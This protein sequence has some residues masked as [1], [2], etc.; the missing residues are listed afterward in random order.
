MILSG[1]DSVD[2]CVA[3]SALIPPTS[4]ADLLFSLA[5]ISAFV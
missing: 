4:E 2:G 1:R 5:K 3:A